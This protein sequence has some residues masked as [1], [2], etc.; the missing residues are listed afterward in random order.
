MFIP[1]SPL[2]HRISLTNVLENL[3]GDTLAY[4][5]KEKGLMLAFAFSCQDARHKSEMILYSLDKSRHQASY[6]RVTPVNSSQ[7]TEIGKPSSKVFHKSDDI[8]K[9]LLYKATKFWVVCHTEIDNPE[10]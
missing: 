7:K 1:L 8:I 9:G 4:M 5:E 6:H 10:D 2:S 3:C